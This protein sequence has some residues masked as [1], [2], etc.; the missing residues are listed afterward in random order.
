MSSRR[1]DH[2]AV[3]ET[4]PGGREPQV[5]QQLSMLERDQATLDD[6]LHRLNDRLQPICRPEP[7]PTAEKLDAPS[8]VRVAEVVNQ[9]VRMTRQQSALVASILERLE[10]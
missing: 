2:P 4:Q 9:S 8:L 3:N 7:P 1:N 5:V 10:I 6:L